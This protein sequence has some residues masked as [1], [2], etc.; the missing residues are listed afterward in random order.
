MPVVPNTPGA[1]EETEQ[2][3][4]EEQNILNSYSKKRQNRFMRFLL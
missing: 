4:K 3:Q 2:A 1:K